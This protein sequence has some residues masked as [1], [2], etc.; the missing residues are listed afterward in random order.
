MRFHGTFVTVD[1]NDAD[2][3]N[4]L[5]RHATATVCEITPKSP[6]MD[7]VEVNYGFTAESY[8]RALGVTDLPEADFTNV[9]GFCEM[10]GVDAQPCELDLPDDGWATVYSGKDDLYETVAALRKKPD[11]EFELIICDG[12]RVTIKSIE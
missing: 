11:P 12:R 6:A 5:L 9:L 10:L 1:R 7:I 4:K 3:V 8:C 2:W